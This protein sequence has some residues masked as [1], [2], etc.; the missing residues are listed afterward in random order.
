MHILALNSIVGMNASRSVMFDMY[1]GR[2]RVSQLVKEPEKEEAAADLPEPGQL[3]EG[4]TVDDAMDVVP[5]EPVHTLARDD[6][7]FSISSSRGPTPPPA[8]TEPNTPLEESASL[9]RSTSHQV[10]ESKTRYCK[11]HLAVHT[12]LQLND[13][14]DCSDA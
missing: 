9:E 3:E 1:K 13:P 14:F 10:Q 11:L 7:E 8:S 4:E 12:L 6:D 5:T 2:K